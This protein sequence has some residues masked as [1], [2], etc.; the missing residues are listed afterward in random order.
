ME[1][2]LNLTWSHAWINVFLGKQQKHFP[3]IEMAIKISYPSAGEMAQWLGELIAT[4]ED[5]GLNFSIQ[6]MA[7][8]HP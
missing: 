3:H 5:Q 2:Y 6:M 1:H 8:K 7:Y 4:P